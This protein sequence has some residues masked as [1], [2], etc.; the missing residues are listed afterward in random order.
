M[1]DLN[2]PKVK[3][4]TR[5]IASQLGLEAMFADF[6]FSADRPDCFRYWCEDP[7]LG[8]TCF[9][10]EEVERAYPLWSTNADQTLVLVSGGKLSY[11][12]GYH[13]TPEV[14][15]VSQT[16]QG[17][18][19]DLLNSIWESEASED[20]IQEAAAFCGF[21]FLN[22][23]LAFSDSPVSAGENWER[24]WRQFIAGIDAKCV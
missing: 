15:M 21:R 12:K 16:S 23:Y 3:P 19:A 7:G 20:E 4:L 17:L 24:S 6:V 10:P 14:E 13:D 11:G 8:W 22:E 1:R 18:L 9:V 5:Q 2:H